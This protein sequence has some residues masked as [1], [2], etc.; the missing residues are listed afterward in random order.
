VKLATQGSPQVPVSVNGYPVS[1]GNVLSYSVT[2]LQPDSTY[3][4]KIT[5][6]GNSTIESDQITVHT[7]Q[8]S[9]GV[10]DLTNNKLKWTVNATGISVWNLPTNSNIL[11]LD[12]VGKQ[13]QSVQNSSTE[14]KLNLPQKGIY[15][16]Q[17]KQNEE[18]KT[19][20]IIY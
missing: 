8:L 19:Y 18:V 10:T 15:L 13:L 11:V 7:L 20:K 4:Y 2:D 12:I 9:S 16:L 5:P 14:I 1:V 3:F 6:E 17:V